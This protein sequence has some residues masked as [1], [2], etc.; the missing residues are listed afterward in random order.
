MW[1]KH[2][3][4]IRTIRK[5]LACPGFPECRNTKPHLKSRNPMSNVWRR[6]RLKENEKGRKYYGCEN[7]PEC[8]FMSWQKPSTV[9]VRNA[10]AI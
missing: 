4:Q 1:K 3:R 5:F 9:N 2:G 8:E 7:N 6:S 10:E